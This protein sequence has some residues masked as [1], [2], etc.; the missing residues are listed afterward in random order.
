MV[1]INKQILEH[2]LRQICRSL[3]QFME[4]VPITAEVLFHLTGT[5]KDR[6]PEG[7]TKEKKKGSWVA[8]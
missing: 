4:K 3:N 5:R 2:K 7:K 8:I 1:T 6:N